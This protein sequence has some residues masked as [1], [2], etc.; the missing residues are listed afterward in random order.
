M[1]NLVFTL[2]IAQ[3]Y[4]QSSDEFPISLDEAWQYAGYA[5]KTVAKQA[6]Q[7][8]DLIED[9]DWILLTDRNSLQGGRP[10][11]NIFLSVE[12]FKQFGTI[13]GT[14]QG[15]EI[16]RYFV[17]CEKQFKNVLKD[18]QNY[19]EILRLGQA[20]KDNLSQLEKLSSTH[21]AVVKHEIIGNVS[22]S[23][24]QMQQSLDVSLVANR[25]GLAFNKNLKTLE[26]I[27]DTYS[28]EAYNKLKQL[29]QDLAVEYNQLIETQ[30]TKDNRIT[31][32][33]TLSCEYDS[34]QEKYDNLKTVAN[35]QTIKTQELEAE[36]KLLKAEID[37]LNEVLRGDEPTKTGRKSKTTNNGNGSLKQLKPGK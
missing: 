29:Y 18:S 32:F 1:T 13:S 2:E 14:E 5:T 35:R 24:T 7:S 9:V 25:L 30:G 26:L 28:P 19:L 22:I 37:L 34:L 11:E 6:L 31:D 3:K 17:V 4:Y 33:L 21:A 12:G 27:Q 15:K 20:V 23:P 10:S 36:N 8:S 16:R